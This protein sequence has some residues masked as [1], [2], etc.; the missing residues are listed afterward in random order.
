[1]MCYGDVARVLGA[2]GPRQVGQTMANYGGGVP[3]WRVLRA[4]GTPAPMIADEALRRLK[5]EAVPFTRNGGRV[6]LE[7]ARWVP[8]G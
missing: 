2:G 6:D 3:W 1:V 4:D 7:Q 8:G 5:Q